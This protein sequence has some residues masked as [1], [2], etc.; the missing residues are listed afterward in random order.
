MGQ[1]FNRKHQGEKRKRL[2]NNM[3]EAE[4]VLWN[5]IRNKKLGGLRF[6]RQVGIGEYIVDF[7]CPQLR[8]VLELDGDSHFTKEA[9]VYDNERNAYMESLGLHVIRYTNDRIKYDLERVIEELKQIISEPEPSPSL[10][11][12]G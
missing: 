3:P 9:V 8:I 12:R 10:R 4:R 5:H 2:R 6:R 7:Y 1:L 11:R